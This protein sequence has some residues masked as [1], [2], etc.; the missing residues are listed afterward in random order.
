MTMITRRSLRLD[1]ASF[2]PEKY[3]ELKGFFSVVM[4][5]DGGQA[6]LQAAQKQAQ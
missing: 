3:Y 2:L 1:N 4:A 5:G 6:V